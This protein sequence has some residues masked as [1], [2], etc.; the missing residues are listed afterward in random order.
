MAG[1]FDGVEVEATR[2]SHE[3]VT[4]VGYGICTFYPK[5]GRSDERRF[6]DIWMDETRRKLEEE[7]EQSDEHVRFA[8]AAVEACVLGH[9]AVPQAKELA[10]GMKGL[11]GGE[12]P[13][14]ML[15]KQAGTFVSL[16]EHGEL[17]GCM[18]TIG[19]TRSSIAD[20]II[21][22]A[23]SAAMRDPRFPQVRPD[24]LEWLEISVDVLGEPEPIDSM[25]E[26]DG[27]R[28]G[29]IVTSGGKRGLLLPD[30][31]GIDTPEQQVD[32]A[33]KKAGIYA[34]EKFRMERFEVIR[35]T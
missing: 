20:E 34:F 28:Y 25:D 9:G 33:K 24:E 2:L 14:E 35:H 12:L 15:S 18:G 29:V 17:R 5:G 22:N 11:P 21:G 23:V 26:L 7:R 31:D 27:K 13:E 32:I 16:H 1:A 8:R 10:A 4:G 30:L 19:P 6:L 3:D